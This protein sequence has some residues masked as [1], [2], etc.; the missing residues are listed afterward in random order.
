MTDF[1]VGDRV[2]RIKGEH[3]GMITGDEDVVVDIVMGGSLKLKKYSDGAHAEYNFE[4]A[5]HIAT[6]K[7]LLE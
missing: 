2:K 4:L 1:K 3:S 6:M 5:N 7:E